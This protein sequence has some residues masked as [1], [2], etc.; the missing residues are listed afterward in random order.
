MKKIVSMVVMAA[1]LATMFS[2]HV[3]AAES[4]VIKNDKT[5]IPDK[6]LYRVILSQLGKKKAP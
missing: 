2:V 5:G 3:F 6:A 1:I 4:D